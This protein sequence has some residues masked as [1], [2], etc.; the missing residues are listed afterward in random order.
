MKNK[1]MQMGELANLCCDLMKDIHNK[2]KEIGINGL[3]VWERCYNSYPSYDFKD[4]NYVELMKNK[5]L[6]VHIDC[7]D[8]LESQPVDVSITRILGD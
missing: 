1:T 2:A 4:P 3:D 7:V 6:N 8:I 5:Y